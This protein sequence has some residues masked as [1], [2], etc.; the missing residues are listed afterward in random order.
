MCSD[1]L[2]L[3]GEVHFCWRAARRRQREQIMVIGEKGR[4][5]ELYVGC[6]R[7]RGLEQ[8]TGKFLE[9]VRGVVYTLALGDQSAG[10]PQLVQCSPFKSLQDVEKQFRC[11]QAC[12]SQLPFCLYLSLHTLQIAPPVARASQTM[13]KW[14]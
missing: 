13:S 11:T 9:T 4:F 10:A 8:R 7:S 14:K 1:K 6:T 12:C 3:R 5:C 2:G